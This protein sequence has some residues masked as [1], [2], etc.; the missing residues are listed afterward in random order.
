[1]DIDAE[2]TKIYENFKENCSVNEDR[3]LTY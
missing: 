1:M 2:Q 3:Y